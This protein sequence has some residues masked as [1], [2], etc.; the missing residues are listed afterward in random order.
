MWLLA[1]VAGSDSSSIRPVSRAGWKRWE[2]VER[3]RPN[4][5][6]HL[7]QIGAEKAARVATS[8]ERAPR[9]RWW[10]QCCLRS[11]AVLGRQA[12]FVKKAVARPPADQT[13]GFRGKRTAS[14]RA[15]LSAES[16]TSRPLGVP[17]RSRCLDWTTSRRRRRRRP[18]PCSAPARVSH[19]ALSETWTASVVTAVRRRPER[20]GRAG[21][22]AA[23]R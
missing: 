7:S 21:R 20:R 9:I 8:I 17:A 13:P 3:R 23:E 19:K 15:V 4:L 18:D 14:A 10:R 6:Q 11:A 1:G 5:R 12:I 22:G 2:A 16:K